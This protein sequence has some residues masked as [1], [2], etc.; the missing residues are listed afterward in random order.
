MGA[1]EKCIVL[2]LD[3]IQVYVNCGIRELRRKK[4]ELSNM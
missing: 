2:R 4:F 1:F 3:E